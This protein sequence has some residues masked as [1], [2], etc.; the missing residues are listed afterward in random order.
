MNPPEAQVQGSAPGGEPK[1]RR[2]LPIVLF[3]LA[4]LL[5]LDALYD[6]KRLHGRFKL[7]QVGQSRPQVDRCVR[8]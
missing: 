7:G 6:W 4:G 3:I 5:L 8:V 1:A 2:W